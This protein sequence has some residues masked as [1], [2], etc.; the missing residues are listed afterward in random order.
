MITKKNIFCNLMKAKFIMKIA[1]I[2]NKYYKFTV[3]NY[4]QFIYVKKQN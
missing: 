3:M 1:V 4:W 2:K